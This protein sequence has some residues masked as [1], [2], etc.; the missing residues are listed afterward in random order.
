MNIVLVPT[1]TDDTIEVFKSGDILTLNGEDFDFS[2]IGEGDSLPSSAI[3]S[4]WFIGEQVRVGGDL[5]LTMFLPN[6][7]NYSQEQAFPV[8]LVG[9]PDGKV[10]L[11]AALPE[12]LIIAAP[13]DIE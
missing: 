11:P 8:P 6:P 12:P 5:V 2:Q 4:P 13:E 1:R 10:I 7:W 3:D 9:V